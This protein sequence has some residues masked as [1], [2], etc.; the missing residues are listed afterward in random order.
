MDLFFYI[1]TEILLEI[2]KGQNFPARILNLL[3]QMMQI[4]RTSLTLQMSCY[5]YE[6]INSIIS[7]L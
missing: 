3:M 6:S 1:T 7:I 2:T 5:C 4:N